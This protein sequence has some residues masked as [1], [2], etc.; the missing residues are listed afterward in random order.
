MVTWIFWRYVVS[1]LSINIIHSMNETP[2]ILGDLH[3]EI[4]IRS[5]VLVLAC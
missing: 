5:L 2:N 1:H 3:R 4:G